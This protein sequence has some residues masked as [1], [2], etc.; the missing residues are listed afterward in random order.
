MTRSRER[1]ENEFTRAAKREALRTG[2]SVAAIL[3]GMLAAAKRARD[4][5]EQEK[6]IQAQKY[7]RDRNRRKRR[8]RQ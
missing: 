1:G 5:A 4:T 7:L 8:G 6:V 2:R 3:T